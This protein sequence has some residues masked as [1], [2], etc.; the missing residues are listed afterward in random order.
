MCDYIHGQG[1]RQ[2]LDEQIEESGDPM[3]PIELE[4]TIDGIGGIVPGNAFH[5]DYIPDRYKEFC[6][7]QAIK[8]DHSVAGGGWTTTI[9]GLPRVDVRGILGPSAAE[10]TTDTSRWKFGFETNP[11]P[12]PGSKTLFGSPRKGGPPPPKENSKIDSSRLTHKQ[13]LNSL[14][15]GFRPKIEQIIHGLEKRGFQPKIF[16]AHRTLR[17]QRKIFEAG[18]SKVLFS[19][20]TAYKNG[21]PNAYAVDIVDKRWLWGNAAMKNGFWRALG[22]EAHNAGLKG[23]KWGGNWNS[24]KD[25]AHVQYKWN[26]QLGA[27]KKESGFS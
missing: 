25:W 27:V 22:E 10:D 15:P 9:K 8:V 17:E 24:F 16:Y 11:D 4:I 12:T 14:E 26:N 7:F 5:V 18:N 13:K 2:T 20:H 23:K 1:L 3:I 19:F 6:V 21:E